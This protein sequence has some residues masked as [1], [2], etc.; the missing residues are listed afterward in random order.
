ARTL[1]EASLEHLLAVQLLSVEA[2]PDPLAEWGQNVPVDLLMNNPAEEYQLLYRFA[3]LLDK[4]PIRASI[5]AVAGFSRAVKVA[6]S[7][8][9]AVKLDVGQVD[10]DVAE[11]LLQVLDLYLH[12]TLVTQPIEFF[13]STLEAL[14]HNT[15][16]DLW[17][18]Q[19]ENPEHLLHVMDDRFLTVARRAGAPTPIGDL[20][21]FLS[22]LRSKALSRNG[23]CLSCE[24][25]DYCGSYFKWPRIDYDCVN[26]KRLF[27]EL[28]SAATELGRDV[29]TF[30]RS[31]AEVPR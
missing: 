2:N 22:D 15:P 11:E 24:F 29:Q 5:P 13:H 16:T 18:I 9:F 17:D 1:R 25:F 6:A 4:H 12:H 7:L 8:S 27:G 20:G 21:G 19:G 23:E 30:N 14:Y 26:V 28:K 31:D 3:K 10:R